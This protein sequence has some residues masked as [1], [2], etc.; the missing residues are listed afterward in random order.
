M[1]FYCWYTAIFCISYIKPNSLKQR[2]ENRHVL[3]PHHIS[4]NTFSHIP[5]MSET[6]SHTRTEQGIMRFVIPIV[7]YEITNVE[8]VYSSNTTIFIGRI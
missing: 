6:K 3:L 7:F 5:L 1:V 4:L 2:S 8:C